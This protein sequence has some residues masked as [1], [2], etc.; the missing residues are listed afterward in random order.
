MSGL[1]LGIGQGIG[2]RH[3]VANALGI[4]AP[5]KNAYTG[6]YQ[7]GAA[8][9]PNL[10][11]IPIK[12]DIEMEGRRLRDQ[13]L[14]DKQEPYWDLEYFA[15]I[16]IEEHGVPGTFENEIVAQLKKQVA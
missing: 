9:Q 14:W 1:T 8:C 3:G 2:S 15:R 6:T 11:L 12:L 10:Q 16:L 7:A 5:A 4:D 13:F